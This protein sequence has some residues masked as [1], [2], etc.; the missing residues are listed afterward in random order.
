MTN[1][2]LWQKIND[3]KLD[4][5]NA[6]FN[7]THRLARDNNWTLS[8]A[9]NVILEYKKF[10]YLCAASNAQITPSDAVDQAW[11]LH[12]TYTKSYWKDF[13][14]KTIGKE[15]HHNPTK[16]GNQEKDKFSNCY[17]L[18][19]DVYKT[20]FGMSPP[21]KIW[22]NTK[23]R[24]LNVNY[25]RINLDNYWLIKKPSSNIRTNISILVLGLI[26]STLFIQANNNSSTIIILIIIIFI[27]IQIFKKGKNNN[28]DGCDTGCDYSDDSGCSSGCGGCSGCG[29]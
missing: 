24:F 29:D 23:K 4:D 11:H 14:L 27:L 21:E 19:F 26:C 6:A 20:E 10:I 17:N 5:E 15:I 22:L 28:N 2:V 1:T 16:G 7:F 13:C 25:K 3:F 8:F 9:Q 12:L 18:T